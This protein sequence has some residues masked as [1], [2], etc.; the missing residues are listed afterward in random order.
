MTENDDE[1]LMEMRER[2]E[3]IES[4][5]VLGIQQRGNKRNEEEKELGRALGILGNKIESLELVLIAK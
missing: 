5:R 2:T 3:G 4:C 1:R